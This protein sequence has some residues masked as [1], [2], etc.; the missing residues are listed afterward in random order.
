MKKQT[1]KLTLSRETVRSLEGNLRKATGGL[2]ATCTA[3]DSC[4]SIPGTFC[5]SCAKTGGC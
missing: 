4:D 5:Y 1:P 2:S 3:A